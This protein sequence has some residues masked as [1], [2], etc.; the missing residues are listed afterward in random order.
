MSYDTAFMAKIFPALQQA[1]DTY[2]ASIYDG[3]MYAVV[4]TGTPD[5]PYCVYQSQDL[6]GKRADFINGNR[7]QGLI[8]FRSIDI[9]LSGASNRL[10]QLLTTLPNLTTSGAVPGFG[11]A[12]VAEK[13]QWFPIEKLSTGYVYTAAIIVNFTMTQN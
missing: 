10:Q 13:P 8:T 6:G 1:F 11:V 4:K 7:W 9:T 2:L 3:K 5:F 12:C